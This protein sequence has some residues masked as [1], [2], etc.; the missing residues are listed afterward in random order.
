MSN[1]HPGQGWPTPPAGPPAADGY[2]PGYGTPGG[3]PNA[4]PA[5]PAAPAAPAS[6]RTAWIGAGATLAAAVITVF[7]AYLLSPNGN[8]GGA[9]NPPQAATPAAPQAPSSAPAAAPAAPGSSASPAASAAAT[10]SQESAAGAAGT[11]RWEGALVI[12]YAEDK[13]LDSTPPVRSEINSEN[14]FAVFQF[15]G[16]M[17]RPERGAK[18]LVWAEAGKVPS[19]ADCAGVVDTQGTAKDFAMKTGMVV[20]GR[21]NAGRVVRLTVKQLAGDASKTQGTFDV[22]VWNKAT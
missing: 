22:V 7:G 1:Q 4:Y 17:L 20:C 8:G 5:G 6:H 18:A 11:V 2:A 15:T 16:R 13:D 21:T 19:Y 14:D 9:K 10:P 3:P 12:A